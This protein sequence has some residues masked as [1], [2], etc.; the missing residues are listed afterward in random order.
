MFALGEHNT[1]WFITKNVL[2]NA[3]IFIMLANLELY[4]CLNTPPL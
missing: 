2:L 3:Y 4:K 1:E